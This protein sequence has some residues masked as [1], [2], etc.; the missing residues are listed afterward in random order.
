MKTAFTVAGAIDWLS[1]FGNTNVT[2][3]VELRT[4]SGK[5]VKI[6][7][8]QEIPYVKGVGVNS[9]GSYAANN[10][11]SGAGGT[12]GSTQTDKVKTGLTV[13]MVPRFDADAE[14]VTCDIKMELKSVLEFVQLSAGNQIGTLTQ[15]RTQE[16]ELN[17]IVRLRAGQTAVIGGI[18]YDQEQYDGNEPTFLRDQMAGQSGSFGRRAQDVQRNALFI[19]LRP[20]VTVYDSEAGLGPDAAD[21]GARVTK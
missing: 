4:L 18:Q 5:Q 10:A 19:I 1:T 2:Q 12:L 20:V 3:N 9:T 15:P 8:G 11:S 7:S 14:L 16:Q 21:L 6:R 13:E 17:D